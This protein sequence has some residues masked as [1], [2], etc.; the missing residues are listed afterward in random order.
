MR[1][2]TKLIL[3]FM[4]PLVLFVGVAFT[5]L[6]VIKDIRFANDWV[7]HT[8]N[9]IRTGNEILGAAVDM[10]TGIR[11]YLLAGKEEFL[12]PYVSGEQR[13][14]SLVSELQQTVS[15]NPAQVVLLGEIRSTIHDWQADVIEPAVE[16]RRQIGHAQ[17]M[18]DMADLVGEKRGKTYFDR[19][20]GQIAEFIAREQ[21]LMIERKDRALTIVANED[22]ENFDE[23]EDAIDWVEHTHTVIQEAQ[24]LLAHA[25]DMETGMRG[26]LLAGNEEFLEPYNAGTQSFSRVLGDLQET[27]SDNPAQVRLLT[28]I[29]ATIDTWQTEVAMP[30]IQLRRDIGDAKSMNDM[31]AIVGEARGKAYFDRFREQIALFTLREETLMEE[32]KQAAASE[33]FRF[34]QMSI[35]GMTL[36]AVFLGGGL[37][38]GLIRGIVKPLGS[39]RNLMSAMAAG[40]KDLT[41]RADDSRRDELGQVAGAFNEFVLQLSQ[42]QG[43]ERAASEDLQRKIQQLNGQH[44]VSDSMRGVMDV[45]VLADRIVHGIAEHLEVQAAAMYIRDT[46]TQ[47]FQFTAGYALEA[48]TVQHTEYAPGDGLIGQAGSGQKTILVHDVPEGYTAIRSAS[49]AARP[50][51]ILVF[52]LVYREQTIGVL[53]FASL[54]ELGDRELEFLELIQESLCVAMA[55]VDQQAELLR[56]R[57]AAEVAKDEAVDATRAKSAFLANM[58]HEIRTP[59][60]GII[61]MTELALDTDLTSEQRDYLATVKS[62]ADSLLSIINDILD[63]SKVEAGK[64]ELDPIDFLLRDAIADTLNPLALRAHTKGIELTYL[65]EPD[66][67][68]AVIGDVYRIRQ[69]LVNLIGNAVKFTEEGE[70]RLTV[71][72]AGPDTDGLTLRF[73]VR[74]T[75]VGLSEEQIK[76]IFE[77]FEQ[78]DTSTT[79]T[80]GGT[81]LGLTISMQLAELMGGGLEVESQPGVGSTFSF[82]ARFRAGQERT[83]EKIRSGLKSLRGTPI[84]VVDDNETNRRLLE[85]MLSNWDFSPTVVESG[86]DCVAALDRAANANRPF[87]L[88]LADLHM[89][90]MDGIELIERIKAIPQHS[91]LPVLLLSSSGLSRSDH[92]SIDDQVAGTLLKPI[93]QSM[94]LDSVVRVLAGPELGESAPAARE[95]APAQEAVPEVAGGRVLLVEDNATNRKFAIRVLDKA[96]WEVEVAEDG[97]Q[98]VDAHARDTFD[99]ILMDIQMPVLDGLEATRE[100]RRAEA[101][102]GSRT[103]I[104]AMTANAMD[105]D[106][107]AC[108]E[109]G[110]DGYVS[111]PVRRE[112][113][114]AEIKRVRTG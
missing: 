106:R 71:E 103:P 18:D 16:L 20:R 90:G 48:E 89:P 96:G 63:F 114:F 72:K 82:T 109:V 31:A 15:D 22:S 34:A 102:T 74:D 110:M 58:S 98:A 51:S 49:G 55:A 39:L 35:I 6:Q 21:T 46:E 60:N 73:A 70:V 68:D 85:I 29:S 80:H 56:A 12:E 79:R 3:G 105:G 59:M 100:I 19:F 36:L 1:V 99:L 27:V 62:S 32:R 65:V 91:D 67:P 77:P 37:A 64:I 101:A 75:G 84:L 33:T 95:E 28:E 76:R 14:D 92:A 52:P 88:L 38:I 40:E 7:D 44:R 87:R 43:R 113:L 50:T 45:S 11:G 47:R 112:A 69:V 4:L 111:K 54:R 104:I 83:G 57:E 24:S 17:T 66:I 108:L 10:E 78:A 8:H 107:E 61:G 94:L 93:K 2:R 13:F 42:S 81:G 97:R 26:Y 23:L 9:V 53:E 86:P 25:I 5:S 30:T 41:N